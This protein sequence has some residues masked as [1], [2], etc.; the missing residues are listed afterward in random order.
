MFLGCVA[1]LSVTFLSPTPVVTAHTQQAFVIGSDPVDGS[2]IKS[3]PKSIHIFFNA[4]LSSLSIAHI[5]HIEQGQLVDVGATPDALVQPGKR[6]MDIAVHV[7]TS[8]PQGSYEVKWTAVADNDAS[9]TYGIIGFNVG[10][11]SMGLSGQTVIGPQ[12]S[13]DLQAIR[14]LD[15]LSLLTIG[16]NWLILAALFAWGGT[17]IMEQFA[18]MPS[19]QRSMLPE[20]VRA[21]ALQLQRLCLLVLLIGEIVSLFL[22]ALRFVQEQ[23][24][25]GIHL[26]ILIRFLDATTYGHLWLARMALM[27]LA[28]LAMER[29]QRFPNEKKTSRNSLAALLHLSSQTTPTSLL[30][31][32]KQ[33]VQGVT[34][35]LP[36]RRSAL[37]WLGL[38]G[39]ITLTDALSGVIAVPTQVPLSA[40]VL[41]WLTLTAQCIWF[42]GLLFLGTILVPLLVV[43]W[44]DHII[45]LAD[46]VHRATPWFLGALG[47]MVVGMLFLSE[48]DIRSVNVLLTD[49]Y[50]RSLLIEL[51]LLMLM[52]F[53]SIALVST[54]HFKLIHLLR[55][56]FVPSAQG[57]QQRIQVTREQVER[58]LR[59]FSRLCLWLGAGAILCLAL[60]DFYAPPPVFPA[61]ATALPVTSA[62]L[63]VTTQTKQL[64]DLSVTLSLL[65]GQI[66]QANTLVAIIRD[67]SGNPVANAKVRAKINM[68]TMDMGTTQ[69]TVPATGPVYTVTFAKQTA[70]TMTGLWNIT[71]SVQLP[72][73]TAL[74]GTFQLQLST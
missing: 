22:R 8:T 60:M 72:G 63:P 40:V 45:V 70:L 64:G 48:A 25:N 39:A 51:L 14:T 73:Q 42:G 18:L 55:M 34:A 66:S 37:L 17:L 35:S 19:S 59:R 32:Q 12:T 26:S 57:T 27:I 67:G 68:E 58:H 11:S 6:E 21:L 54:L 56:L 10:Y 49:P 69:A 33:E 30:V 44:D 24:G 16:W 2:T 4:P 31:E 43:E 28:L 1:F 53:L 65:P 29:Q 62:S 46:L 13:N 71:L 5:Y 23:T 74:T 50:G 47:V 36:S 38:L 20:R 7:R 52:F 9:L 3:V 41:D 61:V 15:P